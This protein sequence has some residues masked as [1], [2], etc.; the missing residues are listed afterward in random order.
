MAT[1]PDEASPTDQRRS[2]VALPGRRSFGMSPLPLLLSPVVGREKEIDDIRDLLRRPQVR[3]VTITGPGGVGKTCVAVCAANAVAPVFTDGNVFV[4]LAPVADPA[5]LAPAIAQALGAVEPA[6]VPAPRRIAA[7]IGERRML[8][9]L[10]NLEHMGD[11]ATV[12]AE[13]LAACPSLTVLATSRASLRLSGDHEYALPPL[14]LPDD[15]ASYEEIAASEAVRLFVDRVRATGVGF[16]LTPAQAPAVA[17][18]CRQVDGLPLAIE[19]AAARIGILPPAALLARLERRL[20]L[21]TG[22]RRDLPARQQTMR[23]TVAWSHDLLPPDEQAVFR[24]L[25][26]F[27][28]GFSLEGAEAVAGEVRDAPDGVLEIIASLVDKSLLHRLPGDRGGVRFGMLETIREYALERL[29]SSGDGDRA[30]DHHAAWALDLAR[31][32]ERSRVGLGVAIPGDVLIV[33]QENLTAA[34][35]WLGERGEIASALRL[36]ADLW[37][38]W[39]ERGRLAEG[40]AILSGLLARPGAAADNATWAAATCVVGA[41]AQAI[42][43]HDAARSLSQ[44]ALPVFRA[45]G[46]V[47][48]AAFALTTLALEAM[49]QGEYVESERLMRDSLAAFRSVGDPRAGAWAMRHLSSLA[50]RRGDVGRAA[51]LAREGMTLVQASTNRLDTARLLLN[52][53][54]M[55]VEQGDLDQA[56]KLGAEALARFRAEGDRWGVADALIRLG[57]VAHERGDLAQAVTVLAESLAGFEAVGDPE[58]TAVVRSHLGW[59]CRAQGDKDGA[60]RQFRASLGIC[61]AHGHA[62]CIAWAR[63]GEGAVALDRNDP[64]AAVAA[65]REG[66]EVAVTLGD[67]LIVATTLEWTARLFAADMPIMAAR[68]LGAAASLRERLG[69]ALG[70]PLRPEHDSAVEIVRARLSRGAHAVAVAAGHAMP[71]EEAAALGLRVLGTDAATIPT[72]TPPAAV[73][74]IRDAKLTPREREILRL[75]AEGMTDREIAEL[76]VISRRTATGHVASILGKLDVRSRAAAAAW[77]VRR[78]LV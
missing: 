24:R 41:L 28:G 1:P 46:D 38:L 26:C 3:L 23:D 69:I 2:M 60:E 42:G 52:L 31:V 57:R 22:G 30:R 20:P 34:L 4:D 65:W 59:V 78:G 36:A 32:A 76:L 25:G 12:V 72:R 9:V 35:A 44:Q 47:R 17:A 48:G 70:A 71:P 15:G 66:L 40:R 14:S 10:D 29:A 8:L 21:L 77:A 18:I 11:A 63:V 43:D 13:L 74:I 19:L 50:Y 67:E 61:Q 54:L 55:A 45:L 51:D 58:G 6:A 27:I 33:E 5:M 64:R 62:S 68:L 39:L 49:L 56:A 53:S 37:P 73:E 75:L 16:A 7:A